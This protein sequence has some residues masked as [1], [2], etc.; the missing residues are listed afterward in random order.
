MALQE[1]RSLERDAP[2][3]APGRLAGPDMAGM[4]AGGQD[5][6]RT[7]GVHA[8]LPAPHPP[9]LAS[10]PRSGL[11]RPRPR[12]PRCRCHQD[13]RGDVSPHRRPQGCN[14]QKGDGGGL[15]MG[16]HGIRSVLGRAHDL[17][18]APDHAGHRCAERHRQGRPNLVAVH[19]HPDPHCPCRAQP[20]CQD[21]TQA[22][23]ARP[24]PRPGPCHDDLPDPQPPPGFGP[25]RARGNSRQAPA[26]WHR[27]HPQAAGRRQTPVALHPPHDAPGMADTAP[28]CPYPQRVHPARSRPTDSMRRPIPST[29][30]NV[31]GSINAPRTPKPQTP[32]TR[33]PD[34]QLS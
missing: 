15:G 1:M 17:Y 11:R 26:P 21:R 4:A 3:R 29:T 24:G 19:A 12:R 30:N 27:P 25:D 8:L 13:R 14:R 23:P 33:K 16:A 31:E 7:R 10:G 2:P 28:P 18:P 34:N 22:R 6:R 20:A 9:L 32:P 5:A